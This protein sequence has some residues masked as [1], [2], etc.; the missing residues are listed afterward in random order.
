[1]VAQYTQYKQSVLHR[2]LP[3]RCRVAFLSPEREPYP[4]RPNFNYRKNIPILS[5]LSS[6]PI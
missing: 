6:F 3:N 2:S 1:M 5:K 4:S